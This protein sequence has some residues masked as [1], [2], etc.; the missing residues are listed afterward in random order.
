MDPI[1]VLELC[2]RGALEGAPADLVVPRLFSQGEY[3]AMWAK[4]PVRVRRVLDE[5]LCGPCPD[6]GLELLLKS[7]AL[8]ALVPEIE[9]MRNLGDDPAAALH[10]DVWEHTKKVVFGV[11]A[12]VEMRWS[13]LFHDI[14]KARTRR[15]YPNG[16][17]TF[18]NHD[19][20][21]ARMVD[22]IEERLDLFS[23]NDSL[24]ITVRMLV[25]NHLRPAGYKKS[26]SDSGVRRLLNDLGGMRNFERLMSLS[27]ADLTTKNPNKRD[28]AL[29]RGRE[30]E[31]RVKQI[32]ASD[33]APKLPKGTMGIIIERKAIPVGPAL[34]IVRDA[35]EAAMLDGTLPLDKDA[36]WYATE[37]L[38]ILLKKGPIRGAKGEVIGCPKKE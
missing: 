27:R 12:Q 15:V 10:K 21:G 25:L 36:Q 31:Q 16:K 14:G 30:L 6:E 20:V 17:V 33:N 7:G 8:S 24:F 37:G 2:R 22:K 23:D 18:H 11:P 26:W 19:V 3:E 38:G 34:T 5:L 28:R 32:Y 4:D 9:A 35:L 1:E 13:A 29:A